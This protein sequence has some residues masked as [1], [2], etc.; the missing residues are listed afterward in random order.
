MFQ[1][2]LL[3]AASIRISIFHEDIQRQL[4]KIFYS[5]TSRETKEP[6]FDTRSAYSMPHIMDLIHFSVIKRN[7]KKNL[8]DHLV[9]TV[10]LETR[11]R[12]TH[13]LFTF[14]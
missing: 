10:Q 1:P 12:M 9:V 8:Y 13:N 14:M 4:F 3:L 5:L 11:L 7:I 6:T 2:R